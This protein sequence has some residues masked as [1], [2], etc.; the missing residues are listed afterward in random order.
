MRQKKYME[1]KYFVEFQEGQ[2]FDFEKCLKCP[3]CGENYTHIQRVSEKG[4]TKK[5]DNGNQGF[6]KIV[7]WGECD[8]YFSLCFDGHK[9]NIYPYFLKEDEFME[10]ALERNELINKISELEKNNLKLKEEIE[11]LNK[12]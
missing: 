6:I 9:G 12:K 2:N 11:K 1:K 3:I 8:H 4:E 5:E 10:R 7:F